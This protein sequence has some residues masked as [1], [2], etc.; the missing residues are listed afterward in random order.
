MDGLIIFNLLGLRGPN[1]HTHQMELLFLD[2]WLF[3]SW[4]EQTAFEL[5]GNLTNGCLQLGKLRIDWDRREPG[6]RGSCKSKQTSI[7]N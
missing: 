3:V 7:N 1:F 6:S 5:F 4:E 2:P